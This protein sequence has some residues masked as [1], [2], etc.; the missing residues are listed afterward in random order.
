MK[1]PWFPFYIAD[2]LADTQDLTS[3]EHGV[4]LKLMLAYYGSRKPLPQDKKK[5]KR[6][7]GL[8]TRYESD[9]MEGILTR[10]FYKTELTWNCRRIDAELLKQSQLSAIKSTNARSI[11]SPQSQSH[12]TKESGKS[13]STTNHVAANK[14]QQTSLSL[15]SQNGNSNEQHSYASGRKLSRAEERWINNDIEL[16]RFQDKMARRAKANGSV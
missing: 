4:Y 1:K 7:A 14:V 2:Y 13:S 6:M 10:Y 3:T 11:R 8:Q 15:F 5:L 16:Q 9:L 12:I